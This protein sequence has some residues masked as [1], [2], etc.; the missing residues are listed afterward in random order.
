MS[1]YEDQ[2]DGNCAVC[3]YCLSRHRVEAE[4]QCESGCVGECEYCEKKFEYVTNLSV[5]HSTSPNCRLNGSDHSGR[6]CD[7][8]G[9]Y[10][11]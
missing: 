7:I 9:S 2:N 8:C 6:P 3:P 5:S 11:T 1:R 4:D 10:D